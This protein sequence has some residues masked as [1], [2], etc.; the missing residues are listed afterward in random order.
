MSPELLLIKTTK[1]PYHPFGVD[2]WALGVILWAMINRNYPFGDD[3]KEMVRKQIRFEQKETSF[4]RY[5]K[6]SPELNDVIRQTLRYGFEDRIKMSHLVK[7]LWIKDE[8][9]KINDK[10]NSNKTSDV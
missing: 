5:Y 8:I 9:Q 2:I 7:H 10:I 4:C 6:P 3:P 1:K